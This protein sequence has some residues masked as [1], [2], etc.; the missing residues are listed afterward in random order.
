MMVIGQR[1]RI[2]EETAPSPDDKTGG[3]EEGPDYDDDGPIIRLP[4]KEAMARVEDYSKSPC[5]LY[6]KLLFRERVG[7]MLQ[8]S[9][10]VRDGRES[11]RRDPEPAPQARLPARQVLRRRRK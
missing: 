11:D 1:Q 3:D 2:I 10:P 4:P 9:D 7:L 6:Q 8:H 5:L